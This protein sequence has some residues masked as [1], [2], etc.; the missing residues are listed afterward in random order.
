MLAQSF[1]PAAE[2]GISEPQRDALMKTLVLLETGKLVHV[3]GDLNVRSVHSELYTGH[4][5]MRAWSA[6][7]DCGTV[8]CIGGT[9]EAVGQVKFDNWSYGESYPAEHP[10]QRLYN[11]FSPPRAT[12]MWRA[13]TD[14]Q[15]ATALRSY[16]TTGDAKWHEAVA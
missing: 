12:T 2:L 11:L 14:A 13:I 7:T 16:L 3:V 5:S 10:Q 9:A 15:A 4:F 8:R 1:L 6:D